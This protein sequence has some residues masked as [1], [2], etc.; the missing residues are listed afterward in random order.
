LC[1][2]NKPSSGKRDSVMGETPGI[3]PAFCP[4]EMS[5]P[6]E[7]APSGSFPS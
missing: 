4:K 2:R 7:A 6:L 1:P 5:R 3:R